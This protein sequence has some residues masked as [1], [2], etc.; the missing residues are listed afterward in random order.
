MTGLELI[1]RSMRLIGAL[2]VGEAPTAE[3]T[4]DC[5]TALNQLLASWS[6]DALTVYTK[7]KEVYTYT[8]GLPYFTWGELGDFDSERPDK[9]FRVYINYP[10][11]S[12]FELTKI[13]T[14]FYDA[15]ADKTTMG[16]PDKF[17]YS[18]D[19]P[20]GKVYFYPNPDQA[21]QFEFSTF[22]KLTKLDNASDELMVPPGWE[23]ALSYNLAIEIAPEF[24][25]Q[26][27]EVIIKSATDSLMAVKRMNIRPI[28]SQTEIPQAAA[29]TKGSFNIITGQ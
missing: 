5:L 12:S 19:Y 16:T 10:N 2:G 4:S 25:L 26:L 8:P 21:Y 18:P 6:L 14:E 29:I 13:E 22:K 7:V 1:R 15:I 11:G 24:G 9:I 28:L 20:L 27:S 17:F 23:R 3:E